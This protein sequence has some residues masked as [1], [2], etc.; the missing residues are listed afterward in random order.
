MVI[1]KVRPAREINKAKLDECLQHMGLTFVA[2]LE[3]GSWDRDERMIA[4]RTLDQAD[5]A[6]D[7][8]DWLAM[9]QLMRTQ[10]AN[11]MRTADKGTRQT[12]L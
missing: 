8:P 2:T 5:K 4:T 7:R 6:A 1:M 12:S 10:V 9:K 11:D 3:P